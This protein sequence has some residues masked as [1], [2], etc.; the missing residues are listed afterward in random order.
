M[1]NIFSDNFNRA[2]N[3]DLGVNWTGGNNFFQIVSNEV[4]QTGEFFSDV[5]R[6]TV[7]TPNANYTV[8]CD[9]RLGTANSRPGVFARFTGTDTSNCSY[10]GLRIIPISSALQIIKNVAFTETSLAII[11]LPFVFG[12]VYRLKI[13]VDGIEV[14]GFLDNVLRLTANNPDISSQG[15]GG[16]FCTSSS[17]STFWDN[18]S[19]DEVLATFPDELFQTRRMLNQP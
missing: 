14:K 18:F 5:K 17:V 2:D 16:I 15:H 8:E 11:V 3:T 19:V 1:A 9:V 12:Q 7:S 13:Q 4:T 6:I 10:Y